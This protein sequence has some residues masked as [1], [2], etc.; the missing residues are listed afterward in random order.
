MNI[1][2]MLLVLGMWGLALTEGSCTHSTSSALSGPDTTRNHLVLD[3]T[4]YGWVSWTIHGVIGDG[5]GTGGPSTESLDRSRQWGIATNP[6]PNSDSMYFDFGG[7]YIPFSC[8]M[9]SA[10]TKFMR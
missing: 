8:Q 7:G 3:T 5:T 2:K 9:D 10:Q 4:R 1:K 6:R